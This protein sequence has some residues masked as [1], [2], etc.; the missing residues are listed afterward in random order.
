MLGNKQN[1]FDDFIAAAEWLIANGYTSSEKL[2]I[3]GGSNGGLLTAACMI[4][5]PELF[6]A[7]LVGVPV[8]DMLRYHL[9]TSGR[10]WV[11]EYGDPAD[12]DHF[13]F[14]M[15][16]SPLHNVQPGAA[17]PPTLV[18]TADTD[19]RVVPMHSL[20]YIATLQNMTTAATHSCSAT[21]PNPAT[22]WA[23]LPP[24]SSTRSPT[25]TPSS[26]APSAS[27]V[28]WPQV[29]ERPRISTDLAR[30]ILRW[31]RWF[32]AK[33]EIHGGKT[34]L[35]A[36]SVMAMDE[37]SHLGEDHDTETSESDT[38]GYWCCNGS[39]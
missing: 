39:P 29:E 23:N 20:K 32:D 19:D 34:F 12:P 27:L 24:N 17:Y 36:L 9:F 1:V 16:Y 18:Y 11:A 25:S 2:A 30:I 10:Y 22:A 6:G 38:Y 15:K 3:H 31:S 13:E 7:V 35:N 33:Y 26:T 5:R 37:L 14:M 21:T 28:F 4:Q 8:I